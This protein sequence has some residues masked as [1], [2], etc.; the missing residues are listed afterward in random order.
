MKKK[1]YF[2]TFEDRVKIEELL[3]KGWPM[4]QIAVFLK[5]A[6]CV[7]FREIR[8]NYSPYSAEKAHELAKKNGKVNAIPPVN[9]PPIAQDV[10][11]LS[12]IQERLESLEMQ[13]QILT[14]TIMEMVNATNN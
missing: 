4:C 10:T 7:I 14:K 11:A 12:E 2:L 9:S 8:K 13:L 1:R 5:R 3:G 6:R